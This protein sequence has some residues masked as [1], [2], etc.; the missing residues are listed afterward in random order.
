MLLLDCEQLPGGV[1][2]SYFCPPPPGYSE[3]GKPLTGNGESSPQPARPLPTL[4]T[5]NRHHPAASTKGPSPANSPETPRP[6][7]APTATLIEGL[8][9]NQAPKAPTPTPATAAAAATAA[10]ETETRGSDSPSTPPVAESI[11]SALPVSARI[12]QPRALA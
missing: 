11:P 9:W 1:N 7:N 3:S 12:N 8:D 10:E 2:L 4:E 5:N 6:K